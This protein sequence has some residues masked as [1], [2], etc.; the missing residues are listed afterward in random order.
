MV[1]PGV[2]VEPAA[3]ERVADG[4]DGLREDHGRTASAVTATAEEVGRRL[5]GWRLAK[6][7]E[8]RA[9]AWQ[10]EAK[11]AEGWLSDYAAALRRCAQDY[12]HVDQVT[13]EAFGLFPTVE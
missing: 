13:A 1:Q 10:D 9:F 5:A 8:D 3:L 11:Q 7:T 2:Q 4:V 12:R 6:T